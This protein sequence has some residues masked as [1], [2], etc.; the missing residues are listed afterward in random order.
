MYPENKKIIE[1]IEKNNTKYINNFLNKHKEYIIN[2]FDDYL[3]YQKT[4]K[5][6]HSNCVAISVG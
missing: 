4:S 3:F 5:N 6:T 1:A 2:A